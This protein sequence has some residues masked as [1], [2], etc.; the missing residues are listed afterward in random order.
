M[1]KKVF[2]NTCERYVELKRKQIDQK[3]HEL[4]FFF[5]FLTFGFGYLIF[6]IVKYRK[7]KNSC[8]YCE[9]IFDLNNIQEGPIG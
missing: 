8:P 6:L 7:R 1:D 3:Y 2:C 4:W 9:D 5:V